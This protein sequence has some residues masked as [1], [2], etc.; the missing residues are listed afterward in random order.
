MEN[1]NL[2][3]SLIYRTYMKYKDKN[4]IPQLI[5]GTYLNADGRQQWNAGAAQFRQAC[6]DYYVGQIHYGAYLYIVFQLH[7]TSAID[8]QRFDAQFSVSYGDFASLEAK[9]SDWKNTEH[10]QGNI[11]IMAY[12]IGGDPSQLGTIFKSKQPWQPSSITQ[13]SF[14][15]MSACSQVMNGILTY[16]STTFSKQFS[17]MDAPN[18]I[19]M[20]AVPMGIEQ[21]SYSNLNPKYKTQTRLTSAIR[22][23]RNSLGKMLEMTYDHLNRAKYVQQLITDE[24][25]VYDNYKN[26]L[27]NYLKLLNN[28]VRLLQNSGKSFFNKL[29]TCLQIEKT[30]LVNLEPD[31]V[32]TL[33]V[34]EKMTITETNNLGKQMQLLFVLNNNAF[35]ASKLQTFYGIQILP[36]QSNTKYDLMVQLNQ[37]TII[38]LLN[39]HDTGKEVAEYQGQLMSAN[40]YKGSITFTLGGSGIWKGVITPNSPL[41]YKG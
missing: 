24:P 28:N 8:K 1:D 27:K 37:S 34:P 31:D 10:L 15:N 16:I 19:P 38:M 2:S 26:T 5:N 32:R 40:H 12:Q 29:D 22:N 4:A 11:H 33:N 13:C 23:A 39:D 14:N 25:F 9:M 21:Q 35:L 3:E 20:L 17:T 18:G 41:F 36:K 6:G 7:F 30:T